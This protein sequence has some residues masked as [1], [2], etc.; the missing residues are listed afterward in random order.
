[1]P[2]IAELVLMLVLNIKQSINHSPD[3]WACDTLNSISRIATP[4]TIPGIQDYGV[5]M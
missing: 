5:D 1:M 2:G 3:F 4:V